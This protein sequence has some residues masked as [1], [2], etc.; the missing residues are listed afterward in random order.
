MTTSQLCVTCQVKQR[1]IT[2]AFGVTSISVKRSVKIYR[3][4]GRK[5]FC[6]AR[7]WVLVEAVVSEG[8]LRA[9]FA[10]SGPGRAL[11]RMCQ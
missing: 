10:F 6:N 8:A 2:R 3:E 4:K 5:G 1:E 11:W 9:S 7:S